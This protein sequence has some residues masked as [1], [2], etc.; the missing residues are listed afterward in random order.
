MMKLKKVLV[1]DDAKFFVEFL[2]S[3]LSRKGYQVSKAYDGKEAIEKMTQDP[4]DLLFVDLVLPKID[5]WRLIEYA[6][7]H[8]QLQ[9]IPIAVVSDILLEHPQVSQTVD[10]NFFIAKG[11]IDSMSEKVSIMLERLEKNE[12]KEKPSIIGLKGIRPREVIGEL[13]STRRYY[14]GI[15]NDINEGIIVFGSDF[16]ILYVN[17]PAAAFFKKSSTEL[18]N[19]EL[20]SLFTPEYLEGINHI[21]KKIREKYVPP[22]ECITIQD[23][24]KIFKI[25]FNSFISDV[26]HGFQGGVMLIEDITDLTTLAITDELTGLYNRK[27]F[28]QQLQKEIKRAKRYNS[29]LSL[30]IIDIDYFKNYNDIYGHLEGDRVLRK[31]GETI[32]ASIR[33]VDSA[34]RYGGEEFAIIL[35]ETKSK[36]A[37]D[38][39]ERIRKMFGAI[40]FS[41]KVSK[42]KVDRV[43]KTISIG[44][45][46][47]M[48]DYSLEELVNYADNAMY[49]AKRRGRN[50]TFVHAQLKSY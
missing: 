23:E 48:P 37:F 19:Q 30:L 9:N 5:G 14:Q 39:A 1:A 15:L 49:E 32:K 12:I 27:H 44:V 18:I 4:P 24:P 6:R 16:K 42:D 40:K 31:L 17:L 29:P 43:R 22:K 10:A 50:Q 7:N 21:L 41:P 46:E 3:M 45:A 2:A 8:S 33:A 25:T 20:W 47:L 38:M 35:P 34:Y 28:Y 26:N 13:L 11:P 36:S